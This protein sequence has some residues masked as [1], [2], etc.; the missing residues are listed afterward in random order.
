MGRA[1]R[2]VLGPLALGAVILALCASIV[3]SRAETRRARDTAVRLTGCP[4]GELDVEM[5]T[6]GDASRW[7]IDGCGVRGTLVCAP[8]NPGCFLEPDGR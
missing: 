2:R 8:E 4:P 7:R 1:G 3:W 5:A 6:L